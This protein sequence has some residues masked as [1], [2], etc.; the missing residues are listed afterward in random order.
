PA[1]TQPSQSESTAIS[2]SANAESTNSLC[3]AASDC[4][5]AAA[6]ATLWGP[7]NVVCV[8]VAPGLG[9]GSELVTP[10]D[11][12]ATTACRPELMKNFPVYWTLTRTKVIASSAAADS[13]KRQP[14]T[15]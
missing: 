8:P 15:S 4:P 10:A 6:S 7:K 5:F 9:A 1:I 13:V 3:S 11:S 12:T 2:A 14:Y